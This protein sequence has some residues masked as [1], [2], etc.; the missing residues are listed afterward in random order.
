MEDGGVRGGS[1]RRRERMTTFTEA[2]VANF[3]T[4]WR[5]DVDRAL[6]RLLPSATPGRRSSTPRSGIRSFAGGKRLRPILCLAAAE[7]FGA[8]RSEVIRPACGLEMI[9]T[10]SLIHDDLPALDNDDLRRGVP[11]ATSPSARRRPSWRETR[12]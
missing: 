9:H 1:G 5:E 2:G 8:E 6:D 12:S 4:A 11:P 7:A 3:L 10:Y